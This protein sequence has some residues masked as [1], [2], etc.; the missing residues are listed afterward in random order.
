MYVES[1]VEGG[2]TPPCPGDVDFLYH[3]VRQVCPSRLLDFLD[4]KLRWLLGLGSVTGTKGDEDN[5]G[6]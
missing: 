3:Y 2:G 6:C 4:P 1:F 5:A